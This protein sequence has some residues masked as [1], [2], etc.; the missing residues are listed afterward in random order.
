VIEGLPVALFV[1]DSRSRIIEF[2]SAAE[3]ITG[4]RRSDVLGHHC[5]EIFSSSLCHGQC[6]LQES[7]RTA[8]PCLGRKA[9]I[10]LRNGS[11]LPILFSSRAILDSSGEMICGIEVFR[12]GTEIL[13]LEVHKRNL[14]SLFAHDLKSPVA[15]TGGFVDRLL[16]GRAGELNQKQTEYMKTIKKEFCVTQRAKRIK[17]C[18]EIVR[19]Y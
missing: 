13:H 14:I 8:R 11:E 2:N 9:T 3:E 16:Q 10:H 15:I 12:D 5:A 4:Y 18:T 19:I 17:N 1:V 6:P 7:T